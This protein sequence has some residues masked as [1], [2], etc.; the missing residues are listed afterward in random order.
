MTD[1]QTDTVEVQVQF[2]TEADPISWAIRFFTWS[3]ISHVDLVLPD[4]SLLGARASGGV[5]RRQPGYATFSKTSRYSVT[6]PASVAVKLFNLAE[7]QE[8]KKYDFSAIMGFI[9]R[10]DWREDDSWFC[11]ELVAWCFEQAGHPIIQ[12]YELNRVSPRDLTTS[13]LLKKI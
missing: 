10:R 11:S 9:F 3:D 12:T 8:G 4:G 5:E 6:V 1:T 13:V 7:A 2:A